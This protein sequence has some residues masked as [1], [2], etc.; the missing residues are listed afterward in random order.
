[1]VD[2]AGGL[3]IF[4]ISDPAYPAFVSRLAL[5]YGDFSWSLQ[6]QN[7]YAYIAIYNLAGRPTGLKV[8][9]VSNPLEP[10]IVSS[11]DT[12]HHGCSDVYVEG[13]YAYLVVPGTGL[14]VADI[15]IPAAPAVVDTAKLIQTYGY[16]EV[17]NRTIYVANYNSFIIMEFTPG[18]ETRIEAPQEMESGMSC[19]PNPSNSNINIQYELPI[20]TQVELAL[21][22]INGRHVQT[23]L[24]E[25]QTAGN[26]KIAWNGNSLSSGTYFCRMKIGNY[27]ESQKM[28]LLK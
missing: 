23:V 8:V 25:Y 12:D 21:Y 5:G 3:N 11:I 22:D 6:V 4:S 20:E 7:N 24:N 14:L 16:L 9:D 26:Y 13:D 27:T 28:L 19:F 17:H 18:Q 15:S 10:V 1:V 2:L